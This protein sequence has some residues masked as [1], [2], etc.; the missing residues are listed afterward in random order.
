ME[1]SPNGSAV[2][3]PASSPVAGKPEFL[4]KLINCKKEDEPIV[5]EFA[6]REG[7]ALIAFI[8]PY[9]SVRISPAEEASASIGLMEE[10]GVEELVRQL[11]LTNVER[12]YLLVNSPGGGMVSSYKIA[13][14]IRIALKEVTTFVPHV[15]ASGGTLL[16]LAADEI[17]MGP[18]SHLT[19]LDPQIIYKGTR[20]SA[21]TSIRSFSRAV[22]WF[23]KQTPD[24]APYPQRAMTD[25]LDPYLM[26]EW[27]GSMDA[28]VDY[29]TEL[30]SLSNHR[31][32]HEVAWRL[33]WDYPT[34]GFV[35]NAQ[36]AR[37]DIGLNIT[38]PADRQEAWDVMR[39]WL[40][41]YLVKPDSTHCIRYV[42][43]A[44][45]PITEKPK[46]ARENPNAAK[47]KVGASNASPRNRRRTA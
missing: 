42:L 40:G 38:D 14:A 28:M 12:A 44:N 5:T 13:R 47:E 2:A 18:M 15:A 23:E 6:A 41:K 17:V 29:V 21:G 33:V 11:N 34:H 3:P 4:P 1:M 46:A 35:I 24:E 36:R 25:K 26:E 27:N 43:P 37:D 32:A 31:K 22:Q 20:I 39:H 45:V 19:P 16:A 30:L 10:F 7:V 9:V 8:A